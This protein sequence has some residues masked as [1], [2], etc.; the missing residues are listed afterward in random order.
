MDGR[1]DVAEVPFVGGQR[2]TRV[3]EPLPAQHRELVLRERR[4]DV[5]KRHAVERQVPRREPGVL[6]RVGHGEQV[7]GVE[8]A[9]A[10]V[11]AAVA[12]RR[13]RRLGRVAVEPAGDVVEVE[14]LAPQH[15]GERLAHHPRLV[16][17]RPFRRQLRVERVGLGSAR[18]RHVVE[19][20][21]NGHRRVKAAAA[22]RRSARRRP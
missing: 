20:G 14:L 8:A 18:G 17:R 1:V 10:G 3:L 9:P 5:R 6:P 16:R 15:P 2:P 12:L 7:V 11:A 19:V 13:G 4:V 21:S 22:A